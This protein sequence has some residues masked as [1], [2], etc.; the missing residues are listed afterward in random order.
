Q[1]VDERKIDRT[2]DLAQQVISR[3]QLVQR[4]Y[5]ERG[6]FGGG[7]L[8]HDPVNQKPPANARGLSAV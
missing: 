5:L 8:Q 6:L 1:I 7:S 4:H 2:I 3:D